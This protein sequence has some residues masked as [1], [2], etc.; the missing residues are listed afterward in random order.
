MSTE[1]QQKIDPNTADVETLSKTPGIGPVLAERI[2]SAR[3]F[4][5]F[6]D[7]Q[8]VSGIGPAFLENLRPYLDLPSQREVEGEVEPREESAPE[9]EFETGDKAEPVSP[10]LEAREMI[11]S[12]EEEIVKPEALPFAEREEATF[13]EELAPE[14]VTEVADEERPEPEKEA[15]TGEA[16]QISAERPVEVTRGQAFL[17]AFGGGVLALFL[18]LGITLGLL[19]GINGGRLRYASPAQVEALRNQAGSLQSRTET[20]EQDLS[21]LR[22]RVDNLTALSGRV[23]MVEQDIE[24]LQAEIET[25]VAEVENM[26]TQVDG[27]VSE[28]ENLNGEVEA[29]QTESARFSGFLEGLRELMGSLF[30]SE[31]GGK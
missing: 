2:V 9:T 17:M 27:V 7:L 8:R 29:L 16:V 3:P 31:G 21:G 23:D 15:D 10:E 4:E 5:S 25:T 30:A 14:K 12:P 1:N 24:N 22:S 28:V 19:A 6:E 18:A 20:L 13:E 11:A 26:S